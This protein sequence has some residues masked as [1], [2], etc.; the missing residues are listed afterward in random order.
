M[1]ITA[2]TT[3]FTGVITYTFYVRSSIGQWQRVDQASN[4]YVWAASYAGTY[5]LCVSAMDTGGNSATD[6]VSITVGTLEAKYAFDAAFKNQLTLVSNKV[7][8]LADITGSGNDATAISATTRC[9]TTKWGGSSEC[10]GVYSENDDRLVT[11]LAM[12]DAS[13]VT[14]SAV[15]DYN[16]NTVQGEY[17][18]LV[19][20]SAYIVITS[21]RFNIFV[22]DNTTSPR[23]VCFQVRTSSGVFKL[24]SPLTNGKVIVVAKYSSGTMRLI[25]NGVTQTLSVTG[26]LAGTGTHYYQLFNAN[27][28]SPLPFPFPNYY[29]SIK[30]SALT[31]VQQDQLYADLLTMYPQ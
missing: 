20:L 12:T 1:T 5:D 3:G 25:I 17:N 4:A 23:K 11:P 8:V 2:T 31:D 14:I 28:A 10:V 29:L 13:E 21:S 16:H 9:Y 24:S 30:Q 7:N 18:L 26:S 15:F 27:T 22:D 6:S 19:L